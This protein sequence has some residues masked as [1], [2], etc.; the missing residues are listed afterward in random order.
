LRGI[1]VD[2]IHEECENADVALDLA[3]PLNRVH[4]QDLAEALALHRSV[5]CKPAQSDRWRIAR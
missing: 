5:Y 2:R 3:T 4:Q 1:I